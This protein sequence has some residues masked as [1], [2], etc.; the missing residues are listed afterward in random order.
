MKTI[1]CIIITSFF[2]LQSNAQFD[3]LFLKGGQTLIVKIIKEANDQYH[4]TFADEN[5]QTVKSSLLKVLIDSV[6]FTNNVSGKKATKKKA[7]KEKAQSDSNSGDVNNSQQSPKEKR[8]HFNSTIGANVSNTMDFNDP[9]GSPDKKSLALN[10][11]FDFGANYGKPEVKFKMTH[12]LHYMFGLQRSG[13]TSGTYLQRVQDDVNTLHDISIGLGKKNRWNANLIV[14][15]NSSFFTIFDGNY[16][17]DITMLGRIQAFASPYKLNVAPGFKYQPNQ[18]LRLSLSPYSF[19]VFGVKNNEV[20]TKGIYITDV[21]ASG[22]F[23][24]TLFKRLGAELN[25]WYD[26]NVKQWL[27]MQYRLGIS[28]DYI[29]KVGKNGLLDGLFITRVKIFKQIYLT[30]RATVQNNLAGNFWKPHFNQNI[31]LSFNKSF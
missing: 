14:R 18:Y 27:E 30:H 7:K 25:I 11:S 6:H 29:E 24:K 20:S 17:K 28:S 10:L 19:E 9:Y 23:K 2:F 3:T 5:T 26:R 1:Y 22:N 8:W 12:E 13:F 4:F 31:M 21:D 16:F 15:A